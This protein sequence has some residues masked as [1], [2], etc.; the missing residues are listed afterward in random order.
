MSEAV[1]ILRPDWDVAGV[2]AGFTLRTGGVSSPPY[3]SLNLA[4]HVGD[5]PAA[6][7]ENRR[8]LAEAAG[9]EVDPAWVNQVH[10]N[11][12]VHAQAVER[13]KT[14]AD[15]V[16]SDR[17]GDVCAV[18]T[19]D[20]APVLLADRAGRCVAAIHAG[21]RG[22]ACGVIPR[23]VDALPVKASAL[24]AFVGP[25][26]G[27]SA[28]RVGAEVVERMREAGVEPVA[29]PI[30]HEPG[31]ISSSAGATHFQLSLVDTAVSVLK[32]LGVTQ[33]YT[34]RHCTHADSTRFYSYRRNTRT[35]RSVGFITRV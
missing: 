35:G 21:W 29:N 32:R 20:C 12:V 34:R 17:R 16:W 30:P 24:D 33:V 19:A 26:I 31:R 4:L 8:R 5:D 10:G 13:G 22:L 25:C 3:D 14:A 11:Q 23:C 28:Y 15:A 6:V 18:L 9:L 7:R 1:V 2:N 27:A